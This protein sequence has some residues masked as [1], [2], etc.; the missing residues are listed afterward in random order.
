MLPFE[1]FSWE[2]IDGK[3]TRE[4]KTKLPRYNSK[5]IISDPSLGPLD[6]DSV[7][8]SNKLERSS[9]RD[10]SNDSK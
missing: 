10:G 3:F 7:T 5:N 4:H 9:K 8:H 2:T 1:K 6:A